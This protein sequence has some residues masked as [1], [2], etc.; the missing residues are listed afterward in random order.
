MNQI[1]VDVSESP[2][3]IL[4]VGH[5]Q[6]VFSA[7]VVVP[8]LGRDEDFCAHHDPFFDRPSDPL[9]GLF[10]VLVVVRSVEESVSLFDGLVRTTISSISY[11]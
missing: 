10:F 6:R 5:G 9:T 7:V 1:Q 11:I 4:R 2:G 8:Q 3:L